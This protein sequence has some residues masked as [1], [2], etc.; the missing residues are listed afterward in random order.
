HGRGNPTRVG[1]PSAFS[2]G[3]RPKLC[4]SR[5]SRGGASRGANAATDRPLHERAGGFRHRRA[6]RRSGNG[7]RSCTW[8]KRRDLGVWPDDST[9]LLGQAGGFSSHV[10]GEASRFRPEVSTYG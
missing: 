6:N 8:A 10:R 5:A 9:R 4:T 2:H 3:S 1:T 7:K